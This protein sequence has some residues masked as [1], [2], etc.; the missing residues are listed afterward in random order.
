MSNT[1]AS[2][3]GRE[4][5]QLSTK[6]TTNWD[7]ISDPI[8][9]DEPMAEGWFNVWEGSPV[10]CENPYDHPRNGQVMKQTSRKDWRRVRPGEYVIVYSDKDQQEFDI[11][12]V[13]HRAKL[14]ERETLKYLMKQN[15]R[16][17]KDRWFKRHAMEIFWG[18]VSATIAIVAIVISSS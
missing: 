4:G 1:G 5:K 8:N 14:K 10:I 16:I 11:V 3:H 7:E 12:R 6:T 13:E 18:V 2:L 17:E 15:E 9:Y